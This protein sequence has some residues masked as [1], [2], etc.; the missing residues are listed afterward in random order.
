MRSMPLNMLHWKSK[1]DV[2]VLKTAKLKDIYEYYIILY[3][4]G[5]VEDESFVSHSN[6]RNGQI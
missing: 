2:E 1:L 3:D 5:R 6:G 4:N